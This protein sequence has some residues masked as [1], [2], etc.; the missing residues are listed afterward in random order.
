MP[1]V[2]RDF[3]FPRGF[4]WGVATSAY[5]IE[6]AVAEDGRAPSIWD[7]HCAE[8]GKIADGSTGDLACDH[9][10][11]WRDD[12]E[13]LSGL[14]AAAYRF[15]VSWPRI[16]PD[17][18]GW[19]NTARLNPAGLDFY[20]RLV[21]E[22]AGRGIAPVLTLFH[23]DLPQWLQDAGGWRHR[24][25]AHRLADYAALVAAR[26]GDRVSVW[27]PVNEMFE[28]C[29]LGH[30]TGEHAPGLTLPLEECFAVA[31]HLL[32]GHGLA[33]SALRAA[34]PGA[35]GQ[36]MPVNSYAPARAVSASDAELASLY[37]ALQNRLFTDPL[38]LGR[39]PDELEPLAAP[40]VH[41]GDLDIIAAPVD[42]LGVNYY[43]IN[44]VRASGGPVPLE[45]VPPAGYPV[46]AFGWAVAPDGLTE[47]LLSL[48]DRYGERL[49]PV[50]ISETG[51]AFDDVLAGGRC[52]DPDR[53]AYLDAHV[54]AT[55]AAMDEG[56]DVRGFY[57]WSLLDNFEWAQGYTKRFG[58]V[59]VDYPTQART[60]KSS[61]AWY[62]D[63]IAQHSG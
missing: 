17:A 11:R 14:G 9:Y 16:Q 21:D 10:H 47:S 36:V 59:H 2:S 39:Y 50:V 61:Y 33:T 48:R 6:G 40:H 43:S 57:V 29:L 51:C 34:L 58:L 26:L 13:L 46:T 35:A 42:L 32:L 19:P 63:L 4:S 8:P 37:D 38:L 60:P 49:P 62:R 52:D 31:H 41:D 55:A 15:S 54:K 20:D 27:T 45:V 44:A 1:V 30:L 22:L 12:L 18:P 7:T 28:H 5:Q 23:W 24:D 25:T 3:K 53:I 56:V